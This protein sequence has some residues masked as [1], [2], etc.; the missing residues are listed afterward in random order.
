MVLF[1]QHL[2]NPNVTIGYL[3]SIDIR[4]LQ[5]QEKI[6]CQVVKEISLYNYKFA[7]RTAVHQRNTTK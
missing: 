4:V 6:P 2:L 1:V 5:E 3:R 7:R